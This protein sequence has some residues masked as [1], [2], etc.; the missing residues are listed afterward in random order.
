MRAWVS[1]R[2]PRPLRTRH[3]I[4]RHAARSNFFERCTGRARG[5]CGRPPNEVGMSATAWASRRHAQPPSRSRRRRAQIRRGDVHGRARRCSPPTLCDVDVVARLFSDAF[6][7]RMGEEERSPQS[8]GDTRADLRSYCYNTASE[9]RGPF[10]PQSLYSLWSMHKTSF[11]S[12]HLLSSRCRTLWLPSQGQIQPK[13]CS[14]TA[15]PFTGHLRARP[16]GG[17]RLSCAC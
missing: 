15:L 12:P 2:G 5:S 10:G 7:R 11:P 8:T 13:K 3:A 6:T 16:G 4:C 9:G 14:F 17:R 1:Q